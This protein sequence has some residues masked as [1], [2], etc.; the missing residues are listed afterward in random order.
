MTWYRIRVKMVVKDLLGSIPDQKELQAYVEK[1][2][3]REFKGDVEPDIEL[4]GS[5]EPPRIITQRFRKDDKGLFLVKGQVYGWLKEAIRVLGLQRKLSKVWLR[6]IVYPVRIHL[7]RKGEII[8]KPDGVRVRPV[9]GPYG[10]ML[11]RHEYVWEAEVKFTLWTQDENFYLRWDELKAVGRQIGLGPGR[12]KGDYG[13]IE[14]LDDMV[15]ELAQPP[16]N[17]KDEW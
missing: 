8:E 7:R 3:L 16:E 5:A 11:C 1:H 15:E 14:V 17:F 12:S 4:P 6:V 10:S 9:R 2:Y 13:R